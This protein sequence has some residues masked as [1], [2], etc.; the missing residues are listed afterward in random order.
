MAAV[1]YIKYQCTKCESEDTVKL[2][3]GESA[4]QALNCW[5]CGSGREYGPGHVHE[6][7]FGRVGMLPVIEDETVKTVN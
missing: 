3:P 2:F 1:S 6:Q 5:N 4:P 7:V